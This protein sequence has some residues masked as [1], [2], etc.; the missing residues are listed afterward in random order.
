MR[1]RSIKRSAL[2]TADLQDEYEFNYR[3][4]KPNRFASRSSAGSR[5]IVLDA[6]VPRIATSCGDLGRDT[7]CSR[8]K[9]EEANRQADS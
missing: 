8:A 2:K 9:Q 4:A 1:K 5:V 6:D 3:K 7:A